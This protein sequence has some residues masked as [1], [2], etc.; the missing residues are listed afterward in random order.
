V[1][2]SRGMPAESQSG[3]L[4]KAIRSATVMV[5]GEVLDE[6]PATVGGSVDFGSGAA[7]R[8]QAPLVR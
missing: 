4:L 7:A 8:H 5:P 2:P 1:K 6:G 3:I